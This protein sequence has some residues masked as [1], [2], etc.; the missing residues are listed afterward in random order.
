MTKTAT[1]PKTT[2]KPV[3]LGRYE[4]EAGIRVLVGRRVDGEVRVLD[5][6]APGTPGR[7]YFVEAGFESKAELAMLVADYRR[8]GER[9]GVSPMSREA[10]EE[11]V[12]ASKEALS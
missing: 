1:A 9:L 10:L 12:E 4:T 8:E 2:G 6:P 11:L 7:S 3:E 5:C